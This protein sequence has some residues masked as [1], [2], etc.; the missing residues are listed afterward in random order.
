M[1]RGFTAP[2]NIVSTLRVFAFDSQRLAD[3][4]FL[5]FLSEAGCWLGS[6]SE[7]SINFLNEA[8]SIDPL[9]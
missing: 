8:R 4:L 5:S 6:V 1:F 2:A 7:K 3:E 9:Q